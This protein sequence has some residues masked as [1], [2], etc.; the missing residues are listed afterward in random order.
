MQGYV[1]RTSDY[2]V[3]GWVPAYGYDLVIPMFPSPAYIF[4]ESPYVGNTSVHYDNG[5]I[6]GN[7]IVTTQILDTL[8]TGLIGAAVDPYVSNL[9]TSLI[10]LNLNLPNKYRGLRRTLQELEIPYLVEN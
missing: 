8:T 2:Y 6:Y 7:P 5:V 10:A 1:V 3:E 4:V 9:L